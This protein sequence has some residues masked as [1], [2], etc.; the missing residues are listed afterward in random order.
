MS[1]EIRV[2]RRLTRRLMSARLERQERDGLP[3]HGFAP[4]Q[5]DG[6]TP[7][8]GVEEIG[9]RVRHRHRLAVGPELREHR[10]H[11]ILDGIPIAEVA[12]D[13]LTEDVVVLAE[14]RLERANIT[15]S[16]PLDESA[17]GRRIRDV[18]NHARRYPSVLAARKENGRVYDAST[19][20]EVWPRD[21]KVNRQ[22][23]WETV[24]SD[25]KGQR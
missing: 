7:H 5:V 23:W 2:E 21:R 18:A 14:D 11:D 4:Q 3:P 15:R 10:L 16:D 22:W 8:R 24:A 6:T 12:R 17:V 25:A 1:K 9:E 20:D 13:G 19:L